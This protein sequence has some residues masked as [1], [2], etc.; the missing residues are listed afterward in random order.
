MVFPAAQVP[1]NPT[2][3]FE[4]LSVLGFA[5]VLVFFIARDWWGRRR[6]WIR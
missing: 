2:G 6:G 1:G 5:A 3:R 4:D